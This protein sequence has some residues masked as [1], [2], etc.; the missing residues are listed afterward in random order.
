MIYTKLS[1]FWSYLLYILMISSY[2][3]LFMVPQFFNSCKFFGIIIFVILIVLYVTHWLLV[4]I[5]SLLSYVGS[6][7]GKQWYQIFLLHSLFNYENNFTVLSVICSVCSD[8]CLVLLNIYAFVIRCFTAKV[9]LFEV[10][11]LI[12]CTKG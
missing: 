9:L 1:N 12:I 3:L 10:V 2:F 6:R 8:F 4:F 11:F 5:K 7:L